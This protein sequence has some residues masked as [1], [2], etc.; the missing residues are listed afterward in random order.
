MSEEQGSYKMGTIAR[1]TGLSPEVLRAWER[2]YGFLEPVRG[3]GGHRRYTED[4]LRV[5]R[6]VVAL[7]AEGR[8]IGEIALR[9]RR[10]LLDEAGVPSEQTVEVS[11]AGATTRWIDE[12]VAGALA[13]DGAPIRN[14]LNKAFS[15]LDADVVLEEVIVPAA[16]TIGDLWA[17]GR[18]TVAGEHLASALFS[19]RVRALLEDAAR[20]AYTRGDAAPVVCC[21]LPDELHELGGLMAAY[22]LA[23]AG[24]HVTWLGAALP[25]QDLL[26]TV[27]RHAPEAVYLSV[28]LTETFDAYRDDLLEVLRE[29]PAGTRWVVGGPGV[30]PGARGLAAAGCEVWPAERP[31][32]EIGN[33]FRVARRR[34][35]GGGKDE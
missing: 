31:I 15:A 10:G 34:R 13:I 3:P 27:R 26:I 23:R 14:A 33:D 17:A 6:R 32:A 22:Y 19:R 8:S 35:A 5:L 18:C 21:C 11:T 24:A 30:P 7:I 25:F 16:R 9:G 28:T 29:A 4:D 12:I 1:L 2:R 20:D